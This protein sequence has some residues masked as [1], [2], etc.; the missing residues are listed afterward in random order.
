MMHYPCNSAL[1]KGSSHAKTA[2]I[3]FATFLL[4]NYHF[5]TIAYRFNDSLD[6]GRSDIG[7]TDQSIS[8]S[9]DEWHRLKGDLL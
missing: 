8:L 9:S 6:I 2:F 4:E 1:R 5:F 3:V 7:A